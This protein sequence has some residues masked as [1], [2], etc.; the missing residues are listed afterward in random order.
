MKKNIYSVLLCATLLIVPN[1]FSMDGDTSQQPFLPLSSVQLPGTPQ[2]QSLC[3]R[4]LTRL[5]GM[6]GHSSNENEVQ[7]LRLEQQPM[8]E[9]PLLPL[10][11]TEVPASHSVCSRV[12]SC[13]RG[14]RNWV[15]R[16]SSS[17]P[18]QDFDESLLVTPQQQ[19]EE[20]QLLVIPADQQPALDVELERLAALAASS[21]SSE[22]SSAGSSSSS[23]SGVSEDCD[24]EQPSCCR[25]IF[26]CK[27][28]VRALDVSSFAALSILLGRFF[29]SDF[30]SLFA[31]QGMG[32]RL[33]RNTKQFRLSCLN[34]CI[35]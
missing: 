25:R 34:C 2:G 3:S 29:G 28:L 19:P 6:F 12:S 35:K 27:N 4:F 16:R 15:C 11:V 21:S 7:L 9:I 5:R 31:R 30:L 24:E 23:G 33:A 22:S 26:N 18:N 17:Q 13:A 14:V 20:V 8:P 1:L 32:E 10:A